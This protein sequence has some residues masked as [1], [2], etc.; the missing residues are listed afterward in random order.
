MAAIQKTLRPTTKALLLTPTSPENLLN[1]SLV[2][3]HRR[4]EKKKG[5]VKYSVELE[6]CLMSIEQ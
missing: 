6:N 3:L 2:S 1:S 4:K 5:S